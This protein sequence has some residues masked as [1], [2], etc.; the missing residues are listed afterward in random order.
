MRP[1]TIR[2]VTAA[3]SLGDECLLVKG[4]GC[5][6]STGSKNMFSESDSN[7]HVRP[8]MTRVSLPSYLGS[9]SSG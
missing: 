9:R 3:D 6:N 7:L 2:V 1:A 4:P 8:H 5:W